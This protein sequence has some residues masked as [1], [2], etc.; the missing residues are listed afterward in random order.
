MD[1]P[2]AYQWSEEPIQSEVSQ[3]EKDKCCIL[4]H[5]H[6]YVESRK[7]GSNGDANIKNRLVDTMGEG[8]GETDWESSIETYMLPYINIDSL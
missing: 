2:R 1:E 3:K 4:T 6:I 5:T 7:M 8:E